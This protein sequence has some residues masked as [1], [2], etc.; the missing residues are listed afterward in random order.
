MPEELTQ[1]GDLGKQRNLAQ[2]LD[3]VL[4]HQTADDDGLAILD[5]ELGPSLALAYVGE[6]GSVARH[7]GRLGAEFQS[8]APV[9]GDRRRELQDDTHV[10]RLHRIHRLAAHG[11]WLKHL[12]P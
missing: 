2:R 5:D 9:L 3:L 11:G 8:H 12:E 10:D 4:A 7:G 1:D 6:P